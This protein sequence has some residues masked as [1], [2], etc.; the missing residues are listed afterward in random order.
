MGTSGKSRGETSMSELS[1]HAVP[2]DAR[3]VFEGDDG[4]FVNGFRAKAFSTDGIVR[5]L[6]GDCADDVRGK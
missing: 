2:L 6:A 3:A 1:K 4:A 5:E